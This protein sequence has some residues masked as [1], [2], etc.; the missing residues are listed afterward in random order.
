MDIQEMEADGGWSERHRCEVI[1]LRL[2]LDQGQLGAGRAVLGHVSQERVS[3]KD[4]RLFC[5]YTYW[6]GH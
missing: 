1:N 2:R 3:S 4:M 6:S 5:Y